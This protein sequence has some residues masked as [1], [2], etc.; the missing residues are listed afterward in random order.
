MNSYTTCTICK[1]FVFLELFAERHEIS[2]IFVYSEF[3]Y[4]VVL[5]SLI[6]GRPKDSL[7]PVY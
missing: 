6:L 2:V 5:I 3:G 7:K 1:N 4:D